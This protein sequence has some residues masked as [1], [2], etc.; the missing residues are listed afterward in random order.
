MSLC[1]DA[2]ELPLPDFTL[3]AG[4]TWAAPVTGLSGPSGAGKTT[5]LEII[6]G[7][8]RPRRGR[9]LFHGRVMSDAAARLHLRPE[10]R[11]C[12]YVPQDLAL[13]PHLDVRGNLHF[14]RPAVPPPPDFTARVIDRLGLSR[15]LDRPLSALSGGEKQRL[16]LARA[17]LARPRLLLLDEPLAALDAPRKA[18]ILPL[19][20]AIPDE[21]QVP[22]V[23][24]THA[25]EELEALQ[26]ERWTLIEGQ[27]SPFTGH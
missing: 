17:L 20:R 18:A 7:L 16:A 22:I 13:F 19:L 25:A 2:I 24:V 21:F 15:F 14:A 12:G 4:A 27:L 8:R 3:R 23:Y 5:L 6:A 1:F 26:A 11:G 9:L 10:H